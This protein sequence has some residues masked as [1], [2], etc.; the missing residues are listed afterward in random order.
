MKPIKGLVR[1]IVANKKTPLVLTIASCTGVIVT[2]VLAAKAAPKA[3]RILNEMKI[4]Q[5]TSEL[6]VLDVFKAT[7]KL[8]A[9]AVG[10][11]VL[12]IASI[13]TM[14]RV[15]ERNIAVLTTG[16]SL[17][18]TTLKE[19]QRHV[20]AEVGSERESKIRDKMAKDTLAKAGPPQD[21]LLVAPDEVIFLDSTSGRTFKHTVEGIRKIE[22]DLNHELLNSM[23]LSLNNV[24]D[25]LGLEPTEIGEILGFNVDHMVDFH[26]SAQL[27]PDKKPVVVLGY[28]NQPVPNYYQSFV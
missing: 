18:T 15:S 2:A 1:S 8:Y 12:T 9:P 17:A 10:F 23:F 20:L 28:I 3:H 26:F 14:N 16:A 21:I 6:K 11:G 25:A 5:G 4:E 13:V 24:Y 7:W 19:Y 22:N 27:T